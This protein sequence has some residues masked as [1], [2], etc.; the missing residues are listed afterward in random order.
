VWVFSASLAQHATSTGVLTPLLA[1]KGNTSPLPS[2]AETVA[3][4][5]LGPPVQHAQLSQAVSEAAR[6][7]GQKLFT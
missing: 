5:A 7:Q 3:Y 2:A 4:G 6:A 1:V